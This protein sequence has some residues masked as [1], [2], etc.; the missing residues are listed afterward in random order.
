M[1]HSPFIVGDFN[2]KSIKEEDSEYFIVEG[3]ASVY[4]NIDSYRDIVMPGA[5][6]KDLLEN[7]NERPILWSHKSDE[8]VGLGTFE[9]RTEGLF[10]SIKLPKADSFVSE[11]LM[12]QIK[13]GAVKGL[14]IGYW[15]VVEE[16][17]RGQNVNRLKECRLRETSLCS[18]PANSAAQ[19]TAAKQFL[20]IEDSTA[21]AP[22]MYKINV[23]G[24][25]EWDEKSAIQSIKD[26]TGSGDKPSKNYG[27][28]FLKKSGAG[29]S[30]DDFAIPYVKYEDGEFQII[31]EAIYKAV[32]EIAFAGETV[33]EDFVNRV[34]KKLGHEEPFKSAGK[35]FV[36]KM[37]LK[38]ATREGLEII[39]GNENVILSTGAKEVIV[40][41]LRSQGSEGSVSSDGD[42]LKNAFADLIDS[43]EGE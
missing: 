5:F 25:A 31:P 2:V 39:L 15:T 29:Q 7:G 18:F 36:D 34:Y 20:G 27:Q 30:F 40:E 42:K 35:L 13:T 19:I 32:P 43:F 38:S 24:S 37:T 3:Y 11:R 33:L 17:D 41:A 12:P 21:E 10:V 1:K 26:N 4:G 9:E 23:S 6:A 16:Y 14:S 22:K 28:F 8:P